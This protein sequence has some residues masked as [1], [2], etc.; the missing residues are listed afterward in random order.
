MKIYCFYCEKSFSYTKTFISMN[1]EK[2]EEYRNKLLSIYNTS[3][4]GEI[5]EITLNNYEDI[6]EI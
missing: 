3:Y 4:I 6:V 1:K 5:R 2:L